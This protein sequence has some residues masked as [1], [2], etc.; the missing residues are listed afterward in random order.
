MFKYRLKPFNL[1]LLTTT[2]MFGVASSAFSDEIDDVIVSNSQPKA[3]KT[4]TPVVKPT[5]A[6]DDSNS[7]DGGGFVVDNNGPVAAPL[8]KKNQ[9]LIENMLLQSMSLM[10]IPYKWGGNTPQT[11]M[12]CSAFV[13]YVFKNS[14][15]IN[16]PRTAAQMA[17]VG[18]RVP[19][20]DLQPGDLLF[21]NTMHRSNSHIGIYLGDNKFIQS[22]RTGEKIQISSFSGYWRTKFNGAKRVVD[23]T[24][25]D[26][27]NTSGLQRF[28][29]ITDQALPVAKSSGKSKGRNSRHGR[30]ASKKSK[31]TGH[32]ATK[33]ATNST[34]KK[35]TSKKTSSKK[36]KQ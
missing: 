16:L 27:G 5:V 1:V 9:D 3:K 8:S 34:S 17:R 32:S 21:F 20:S 25:D 12:D 19:L 26:D 35:A 6:S 10:G 11:G 33:K 18:K 2:L 30:A 24:L 22:P 23:E 15:G 36:K 28:D 13:R 29:N 14:L 4:N 7:D 31:S